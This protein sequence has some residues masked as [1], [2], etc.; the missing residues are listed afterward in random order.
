MTFQKQ[1][2]ILM[3]GFAFLVLACGINLE[4]IVEQVVSEEVTAEDVEAVVE[5]VEQAAVE[6]EIVAAESQDAAVAANETEAQD[7]VSEEVVVTNE[8]QQVTENEAVAQEESTALDD[9][10]AETT[11]LAAGATGVALP[12]DKIDIQGLLNNEIV[13]SYQANYHF[14]GEGPTENIEVNIFSEATSNPARSHLIMEM[15][16]TAAQGVL[17]R[18]EIYVMT[19]GGATTMFM[20]N[21]QDQ[22]W[23]AITTTGNENAFEMLPISPYTQLPPQSQF[24]GQQEVNG[25]L[26]NYYT[27]NQEDYLGVLS[28]LREARGEM[29]ITDDQIIMKLIQE[30]HAGDQALLNNQAELSQITD[31]YM[32]YEIL[33]LNN[34]ALT[35]TP[36]EEALNSAPLAMP[37]GSDNGGQS[38]PPMPEDAQI[39]VASGEMVNFSTGLS[40]ADTLQFYRNIWG[41]E[42]ISLTVDT[43]TSIMGTYNDGSQMT[44]FII[45]N[46]NGGT[47]VFI[48]SP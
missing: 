37:G 29:W 12:V 21:P 22:S 18:M 6:G 45:S 35:I 4:N 43:P 15:S 46:E 2:I 3:M 11:D 7:V 19:E 47:T 8:E 39:Q 44:Q 10:S 33:Q 16:G 9:T 14:R 13:D 42:N 25:V 30:L 26:T 23:T 20:Q 5:V 31:I 34:S 1:L 41:A 40:V 17:E 24:G 36:P 38:G 32:E 28:G 27:Y 48:T